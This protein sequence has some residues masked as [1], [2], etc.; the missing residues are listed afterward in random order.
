MRANYAVTA[1]EPRRAAQAEKAG[2][3]SLAERAALALRQGLENGTPI[4][5][6]FRCAG[7]TI[8]IIAGDD[9]LRELIKIF[10]GGM[11]NEGRNS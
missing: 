6:L 3:L 5:M 9:E 8:A 1:Q 2:S 4:E 11:K 10:D 7:E